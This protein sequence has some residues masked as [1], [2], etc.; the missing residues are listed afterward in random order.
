VFSHEELKGQESDLMRAKNTEKVWWEW[1]EESG[2]S[3]RG[4]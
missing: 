1:R 3:G 2:T 4:M